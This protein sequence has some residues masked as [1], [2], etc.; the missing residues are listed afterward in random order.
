MKDMLNLGPLT[1]EDREFLGPPPLV[2]EDAEH[3]K[4]LAELNSI[5]APE[6]EDDASQDESGPAGPGGPANI[7]PAEEMLPQEVEP[8]TPAAAAQPD[9]TAKQSVTAREAIPPAVKPTPSLPE[10]YALFDDGVYEVSADEGQPPVFICT[11]LRVEAQ[12]SDGDGKASG[13]LISI[14]VDGTWREIPIANRELHTRTNEVIGKLV[15]HGLELGRDKQ[16][17]ERLLELL[18]AWKPAERLRTVQSMGWVDDTFS[19]FVCGANTI[20]A[21]NVIFPN[22]HHVEGLS[23]R[24]DAGAW[25][26]EVGM[27]CRGNPLMILAT[28]LAFSGPLLAPLGLNGGGLHF[29]GASSTGKTTLLSLA[30]SVWGSRKLIKQW[31]ATSNALEGIATASNDMLLP[32]DEIGEI[33]A[34]DLHE[35]AYML[36]NGT[37]KARMTKD[38]TMAAQGRW[39][40]ALISSGEIS[41]SEKLAEANLTA[42]KGQEVR[43]IDIGADSRTHGAFDNLHGENSPAVFASMI[44][45]ASAALFGAAG[46]EFVR[47]LIGFVEGGNMVRIGSMIE[48]RASSWLAELPTVPDGPTSRVAHRLAVIGMAGE[49]ATQF[50]LTGWDIPEAGAAAKEAFLDWY[51]RRYAGQNELLAPSV[52]ALQRFMA[53]ELVGLPSVAG[54]HVAGD[55]PKGWRDATLLYLTPMTWAA[56]FPGDDGLKV[57]KALREVQM[58]RPEGD[59]IMRKAPRSIP[60]RPRLFTLDIHRI[61]KFKAD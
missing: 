30:A 14:L 38:L 9:E 55:E 28:S 45:R 29:R 2:D 41:V 26:Q 48:D 19:S 8:A 20:G 50:G 24:G 42:M 61:Q 56:I 23:V 6:P 3:A 46:Q 34:R 16:S 35:A 60:G 4:L 15:D 31:R 57:A 59:R 11:P 49:L 21:Q 5:R 54:P 17:K 22:A 37:G 40:L 58:L 7:E 36:A 18:K 47:K 52:K 44:Q 32:L 27:K 53:T 25:K 33:R 10:G 43:L 51:D 1:D 12:F 13:R 39:R